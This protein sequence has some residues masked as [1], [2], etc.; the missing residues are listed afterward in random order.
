MSQRRRRGTTA[1]HIVVRSAGL[2]GGRS[3]VAGVG[4]AA[5]GTDKCEDEDPRD[6]VRN[7]ILD[8]NAPSVYIESV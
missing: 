4:I 1:K 3:I 8:H 7:M 2:R 5:A 6:Q